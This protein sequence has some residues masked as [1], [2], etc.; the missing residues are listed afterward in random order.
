MTHKGSYCYS[1]L[2]YIQ[3][4][5][6][7]GSMIAEFLA[8]N[9]LLQECVRQNIKVLSVFYD[10]EGIRHYLIERNKTS[11]QCMSKLVE[12]FVELTDKISVHFFKI[13]GHSGHFGNVRADKCAK[14]AS[15]WKSIGDHE[16]QKCLST[17]PK[18]LK[19]LSSIQVF[20]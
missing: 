10:C 4:V 6:R 16:A 18:N 20:I 19:K 17:L 9:A 11:D 3:T 1:A 7:Y 13:A 8:V 2:K 14:E 12:E 15:G 5:T